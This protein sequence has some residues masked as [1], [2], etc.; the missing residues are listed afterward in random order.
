MWQH[1]KNGSIRVTIMRVFIL[2]I[3]YSCN[4]FA[5]LKSFK[6]KVVGKNQRLLDTHTH[7]GRCPAVAV[8]K[9][10]LP[11]RK[12]RDTHASWFA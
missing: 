8:A 9:N 11:G 2:L 3:H 4:S 1:V 5:G 10:H 7:S 12:H 6:L